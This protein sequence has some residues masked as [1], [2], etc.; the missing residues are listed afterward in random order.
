MGIDVLW[1]HPR[2]ASFNPNFFTWHTWEVNKYLYWFTYEWP[3]QMLYFFSYAP[4]ACDVLSQ[5]S[6]LRC[7]FLLLRKRH[8]WFYRL[9]LLLTSERSDSVTT[10]EG[11]LNPPSNKRTELMTESATHSEY[12]DRNLLSKLQRQQSNGVILATKVLSKQRKW[13]DTAPCSVGMLCVCVCVCYL[14]GWTERGSDFFISKRS[15]SDLLFVQKE[16][17]YRHIEVSFFPHP[18]VLC[19]H[20]HYCIDCKHGS[21]G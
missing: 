15:L 9:R 4:E 6:V 12:Q 16:L 13:S 14:F 7:N 17:K 2:M 1:S 18:Q 10:Y 5:Q 3:E 8:T 20:Q 19:Q 21:C 11:E